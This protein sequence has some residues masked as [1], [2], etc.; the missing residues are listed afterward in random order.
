M[1][2]F[3][4][5]NVFFTSQHIPRKPKI[6]RQQTKNFIYNFLCV[7]YI[8]E[9]IKRQKVKEKKKQKKVQDNEIFAVCHA[10]IQLDSCNLWE[11]YPS[12]KVV[13]T[14]KNTWRTLFVFINCN[15][16]DIK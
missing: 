4:R 11:K 12:H 13:F 9:R 2:V 14:R 15:V 7:F 10:T 3:N 5:K 6:P 8:L 1:N 16:Y